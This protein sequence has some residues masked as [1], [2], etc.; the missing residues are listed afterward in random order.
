M[1]SSGHNIP[2]N[3][4]NSGPNKQSY[5]NQDGTCGS[6]M[7]PLRYYGFDLE[8]RPLSRRINMYELKVINM[9]INKTND[10]FN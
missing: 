8:G 7:T 3:L 10:E 2:I 5:V 1:K 9:S 6:V 4:R